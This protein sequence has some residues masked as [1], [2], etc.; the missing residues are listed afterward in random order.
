ME[1]NGLKLLK[2]MKLILMKLILALPKTTF[3]KLKSLLL[4]II[5]KM[6]GESEIFLAAI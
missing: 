5:S 2:D 4:K 6:I 3:L 1:N